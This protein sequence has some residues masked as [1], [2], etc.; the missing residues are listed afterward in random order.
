V[1]QDTGR[2]RNDQTIPYK[3]TS[4]EDKWIE[5]LFDSGL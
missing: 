4:Q 2:E 5:A 1:S 3:Y